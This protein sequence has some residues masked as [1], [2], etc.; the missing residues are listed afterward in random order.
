MAIETSHRPTSDLPTLPAEGFGLG[1]ELLVDVVSTLR[2]EGFDLPL[3]Y[4]DMRVLQLVIWERVEL[5]L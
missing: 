4:H 2:A 3:E 1:L 5:V